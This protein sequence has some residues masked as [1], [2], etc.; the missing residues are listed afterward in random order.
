MGSHLRLITRRIL[1]DRPI[2]LQFS[3]NS[4]WR[5]NGGYWGL[6]CP[7][8]WRHDGRNGVSNHRFLDCLLKRLFRR[9]LKKT[10]KL[11]VTGLCEGNPPVTGGFPSQ[12]PVTR[13][14]FPFDDVILHL[15]KS[16]RN[17]TKLVKRKSHYVQIKFLI[18]YFFTQQCA[19]I[20]AKIIRC[21]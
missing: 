3:R 6:V 8:P 7:L 17:Y 12:R 19:Q 14:M 2:Q 4:W 11:Y 13:K 1:I 21:V 18:L 16:M 5:E 20:L 15:Y 10:S 9:S